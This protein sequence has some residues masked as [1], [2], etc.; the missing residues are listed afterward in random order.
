MAAMRREY[1][2]FAGPIIAAL[3]AWVAGRSSA[4]SP[5][6]DIGQAHRAVH[7]MAGTAAAYG[8][9]VLGAAA[10]EAEDAIAPDGAPIGDGPAWRAGLTASVAALERALAAERAALGDC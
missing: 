2:A 3:G 5:V 4:D 1:L 6:G 7:N 10:R 9:P 8:F